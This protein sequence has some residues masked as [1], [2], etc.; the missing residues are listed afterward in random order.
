MPQSCAEIM[1]CIHESL[2][3]KYRLTFHSLEEDTGRH[4]EAIHLIGGGVKDHFLCS[5]TASACG[6]EVIAGPVE[7][8]VLG[9]I[10][11]QL[12]SPGELSSIAQERQ[13]I[14]GSFEL[15]HYEP[16]EKSMWDAAAE[17]F[18]EI[19]KGQPRDFEVT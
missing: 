2:A 12:I 19:V 1:R 15:N 7:A 18:S 17:R 3:L 10:A 8:T 4:F 11:V 14:A 13:V 5:L 16:L 9:N 6:C